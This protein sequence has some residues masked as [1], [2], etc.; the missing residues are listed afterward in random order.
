MWITSS[1]KMT[2]IDN[3]IDNTV[4]YYNPTSLQTL[5]YACTIISEDLM[6]VATGKIQDHFLLQCTIDDTNLLFTSQSPLS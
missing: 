6:Y 4:N 5:S 2:R 3:R 1:N